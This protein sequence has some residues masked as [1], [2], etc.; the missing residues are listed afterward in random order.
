MSRTIEINLLPWREKRRQQRT[1]RLK[2]TL[3]GM[4]L[5]GM[6]IGWGMAQFEQSRVRAQ[7]ARLAMIDR[8]TQALTHDIEAVRD[9]RKLRE[10]MLAQ[11]ELIG[12]L[13]ASRPLTVEVFDQLSASLVDGVHYTEMDRQGDRL[14][15]SGVASS[16]RQV[17]SQMRA[18][19]DSA[20]FG[21]PLLS[22][23]QTG[24]GPSA[25]KRFHMSVDERLPDAR[26][27][28]TGS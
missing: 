11:I 7:Q 1:R 22:D 9:Y 19:E 23:V 16:N 24:E 13:Q 10:R 5:L 2:Q 8:N 6:L 27:P 25:P 4:L 12:T 26:S 18:L 3:L 21:T 15:L 14:E 20:V 28:E 17:S